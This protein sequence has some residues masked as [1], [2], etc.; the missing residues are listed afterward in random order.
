FWLDESHAWRWITPCFVEGLAYS[1]ELRDGLLSVAESWQRQLSKA[2]KTRVKIFRNGHSQTGDINDQSEMLEQLD[3]LSK[4]GWLRDGGDDALEAERNAII[5]L[6]R[7]WIFYERKQNENALEYYERAE[8][9]LPR[10]CELLR[11]QLAEY[12]NLL[13]SKFIWPVLSDTAVYSIEA[14]RILRKVVDWTPDNHSAWYNLGGTLW[15]YGGHLEDAIAAYERAIALDPKSAPPYNGL[16]N[17]YSAQGRLEEA[18]AA[19][20]RAIELDPKSAPP[21]NGLGNVY[22]A[23]G[24]LRDAMAAYERA[25]ELNPKSASPHNGLGNVYRDQG[26][27]EDAMASYERAIELDP[28]DAPPPNGLGNFY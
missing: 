3:R 4:L 5:D 13:A 14:E 27:L 12:L 9:G 23:Q 6:W 24:R 22:S 25:I 20:E 16:G 26:R 8:T 17:V 21:H 18:M 1:R 19:Y 15:K 2:G 28:K 7:G 10:K 11:Q